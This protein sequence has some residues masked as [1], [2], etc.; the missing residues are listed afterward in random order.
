MGYG[1]SRKYPD[2]VTSPLLR[3]WCW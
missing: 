1:G 3:W 2:Q